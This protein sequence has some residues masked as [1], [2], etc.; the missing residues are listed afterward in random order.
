VIDLL[1]ALLAGS[2]L[3]LIA[4]IAWPRSR[5]ARVWGELESSDVANAH[6]RH[7]YRDPTRRGRPPASP[8]AEP[9]RRVRQ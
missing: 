2:G 4:L 1:V 3:F 7:P 9:N 5:R 6:R 8:P